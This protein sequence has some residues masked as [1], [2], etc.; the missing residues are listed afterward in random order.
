MDYLPVTDASGYQMAYAGSGKLRPGYNLPNLQLTLDAGVRGHVHRIGNGTQLDESFAP[1]AAEA[2][3]VGLPLGSFWYIQPYKMSPAQAYD[4]IMRHLAPYPHVEHVQL[5]SEKIDNQVVPPTKQS[6]AFVSG[7]LAELARRISDGWRKPLIY[8]GWSWWNSTV[9][10]VFNDFT[11]YDVVAPR[12]PY[13]SP[14]VP[15]QQWRQPP[16]DATQWTSWVRWS[17]Q[18][19]PSFPNLAPYGAWQFTSWLEAH[20]FGWPTDGSQRLDGSL[21]GAELFARAFPSTVAATPPPAVVPDPPII[22]Q[23][24]TENITVTTELTVLGRPERPYDSRDPAGVNP[25]QANVPRAINSGHPGA[26][27]AS[28][29]VEAPGSSAGWVTFWD[30]S[31]SA[32]VVKTVGIGSDGS[33]AIVPLNGAGQFVV[34]ASAP[35]HLVIDLQA[36]DVV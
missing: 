23:T 30:G 11:M 14:S 9:G 31:G 36:I 16:A 10:G 18:P 24:P 26:R 7:W 33:G 19:R 28:I 1:V 20:R 2:W 21:Y 27:V 3:A 25:L 4:W 29:H 35:C 17:D 15:Q 34:Q 12:Y 8:T 13:Q 5:D 22:V 32:P 6:Q